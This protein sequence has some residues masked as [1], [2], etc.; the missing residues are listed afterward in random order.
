M[1]IISACLLGISCR[2][3][4]HS[5]TAEELLEVLKGYNIVPVCPEQ[6]GGLTTPRAPSEI[7]NQTPR[8]IKDKFG[9]DVT[10]AFE[11]GARETVTIA[12]LVHAQAAI[13]KER[14]P[15]CG[16]NFI[17]DG[18]FSGTTV[19]GQG[20]AARALR[21]AGISVYS[22]EEIKQFLKE[23]PTIK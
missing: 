17:Y 23:I 20:V 18:T 7:V 16:C 12:K 6:L 22:E 9:A 8:C 2:Y 3:D 4:G 5:K 11:K 10:D 13:L 19:P 14:S 21:D 1:I 15:S